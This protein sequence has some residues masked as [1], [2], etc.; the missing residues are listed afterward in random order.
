MRIVFC[1][2]KLNEIRSLVDK[3]LIVESVCLSY[4]IPKAV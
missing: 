1:S 3:L 2:Y 4:L